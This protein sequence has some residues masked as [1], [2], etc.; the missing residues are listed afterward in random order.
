MDRISLHRGH[1]RA[2]SQDR[3]TS[4]PSLVSHILAYLAPLP[5][6]RRFPLFERT[7]LTDFAD[8]NLAAPILQ[9]LAEENYTTPTPI[10]A[11]AIP[12]AMEGHDI[13]GLAQ[14]G[15]GKTA[16]FSLPILHRLA[17]TKKPREAKSCR[18]LILSPTR[19]LASQICDS[20]R[21]YGKHLR[22]STG[23]VLGGV[24]FRAQAERLA[25]GVDIVV[26]TPGRLID[27]LD[28]KTINLD[29]V[30]VVVLDEAD[31]M[32][33]MGFV[34]AIRRIGKALPAERQSL[35]FSATM[36]KMIRQLAGELLRDPIEVAVAKANTTAAAI[37][38]QVIFVE[39]TRKRQVLLDVLREQN[40]DR[41]LIFTRTKHGANR[42]AE[43]L[44][45][46]EI[47]AG[48]IHGNKSQGQR[49]RAL[50]GFRDGSV[51]VLVATDIAARG[52]DVD[53]VSHVINFDLPN[54]SESYVHRIG[55][56]A[57][58]GASGT[59]ISFCDGDERAYLR[60]IEGLIRQR[61]A[62]SDRRLP[63]G[64]AEAK[65]AMAAA[66]QE[67]AEEAAERRAQP[68][69]GHHHHRGGQQG[70]PARNGEG[71]TEAPVGASGKPVQQ[72]QNRPHNAK[73]GPA[74]G[75]TGRGHAGN[76][77]SGKGNLPGAAAKSSRFKR[78]KHEPT[79]A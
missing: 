73:A 65:A 26:A 30:E 8:L 48:A 34:H 59:A 10:Q 68:P 75:N 35:F 47:P 55:R 2:E 44:E 22:L 63:P 9:A 21:A 12:H 52:I 64:S 56:T 29:K 51:K 66:R 50:A 27:H 79:F 76:G 28:Q 39:T 3:R 54:V 58:N 6:L 20:V 61:I 37:D 78:Q 14:T 71:R 11:Q 53:G 17:V 60:S 19:E 45:A 15:T 74:N 57:R 4:N 33:D 38:Q 43:H 69:Q 46:N 32:L 41:V 5:P 31:Q 7:F 24:S 25:R 70:R 16:A 42:V 72:R 49:E 13:L 18:A 77:H 62:S 67:R 40:P 36:P 23:V 1:P